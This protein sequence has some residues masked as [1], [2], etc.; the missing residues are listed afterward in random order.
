MLRY[1]FATLIIMGMTTISA[2]ALDTLT[3]GVSELSGSQFSYSVV[4]LG[5]N[6]RRIEVIH[7]RKKYDGPLA[8][9]SFR[10][11]HLQVFRMVA[12]LIKGNCQNGVSALGRITIS[13]DPEQDEDPAAEH[14]QYFTWEY[15]CK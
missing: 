1:T 11:R 4:D 15:T 13:K 12:G 14:P 9:M 5:S 7:D 3:Q 2:N 10:D 8:A 6:E